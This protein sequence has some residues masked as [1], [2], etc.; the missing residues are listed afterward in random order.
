MYNVY[1]EISRFYVQH[2]VMYIMYRIKHGLFLLG[3]ENLVSHGCHQG[4]TKLA[5]TGEKKPR[6]YRKKKQ[7]DGP[8]PDYR[9]TDSNTKNNNNCEN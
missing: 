9:I 2:I 5:G 8:V 1:K 3:L 6:L 4:V 7:V